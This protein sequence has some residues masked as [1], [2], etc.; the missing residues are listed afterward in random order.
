MAS[1]YGRGWPS[2][3]GYRGDAQRE[4]A[5][6]R[7]KNAL[8]SLERD[9]FTFEQEAALQCPPLE[10]VRRHLS[11]LVQERE[12]GKPHSKVGTRPPF[13]LSGDIATFAVI[14]GK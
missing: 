3:T 9:P 14:W 6:S 12:G 13:M 1:S 10:Q 8:G 7:L 2:F 11:P 4:S 5:D